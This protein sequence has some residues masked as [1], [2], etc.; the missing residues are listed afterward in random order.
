MS[1]VDAAR[2]S[3]DGRKSK[4]HGFAPGDRAIHENDLTGPGPVGGNRTRKMAGIERSPRTVLLACLTVL[5]LVSSA[6]LAIITLGPEGLGDRSEARES[7]IN[8]PPV[9]SCTISGQ[10]I[11]SIGGAVTFKSGS[12]DPDGTI[13]DFQWDFGDGVVVNGTA[14][15]AQNTTHVYSCG[16]NYLVMHTVRDDG[17]A[18]AS[19]ETSMHWVCVVPYNPDPY[20]PWDNSTTPFAVLSSDKDIIENNTLVNFN[21]TG[22]YGIGGW[23][24][25]NASDP[26]MGEDWNAGVEYITSMVLDFG[27]GTTPAN[28]STINM[29]AAH[30]YAA[31]GH[32]AARLNIT[33]N[34]SGN[35]V[36]TEI[37]ATIHVLSPDLVV[38]EHIKNPDAVV[39]ATIGEPYSLDPAINYDSAGLEVMMSVYET[40]V[41]YDGSSAANLKPVLAQEIPTLTNGLISS[42][43]LN[44][45]F[46]IRTGITFHD[47][48]ALTADDVVYSL[49][50]VLRIHDPSSP[51]WMMSQVLDDYIAYSADRGRTVGYFLDQSAYN[52]TSSALREVLEPLG[53]SHIITEADVQAVAEHVITKVNDTMVNIRLLKPY[54]GF[55][56]ILAYSVGDIVSKDFVEAHGGI[57]NGEVN[58]YMQWHTCGTG[59]YLLVSWEIGSYIYM[60]RNDAYWGPR[61]ALKDAYIIKANDVNTRIS[62]LQGGYADTVYIPVKY[63]SLFIDGTKYEVVK[64]YPT[65]D[66]IFMA[67][68]FNL[69]SATAISQYGGVAITDTFFHDIQVRKAFS[70]MFNFSQ[71]LGNV[72][73]GNGEQPNGVIPNGMWGYDA[74][75]PKYQYSLQLAA[76]DLKN[77]TSPYGDSWFEHGFVLPMFYN[78][79]NLGRQTACEMIHESLMALS[80]MP[81]AGTIDATVNPLDWPQ[82]LAQMYNDYGFMGLYS[83]GWGADFADPDDY[84]VPMLDPDYGTYAFFNGYRNDSITDLLRAAAVELDDTT[85]KQMYSD[86]SMMVY[87]DVPY[88]WLNQPKSFHVQRSWLSGYQF[89]PM[90]WGGIYFPTLSKSNVEPVASFSVLPP[91]GDPT[92]VFTFD[93]WESYDVEDEKSVLEVRW[94]WESDGTWDTGWSTEKIATHQYPVEG[95]YE[96]ALE[97]RDS[98]GLT[99]L[100][101]GTVA[102]EPLIPEFTSIILPIVFMLVMVTAIRSVRTRRQ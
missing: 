6:L 68:N 82:Y 41:W 74:S 46:N 10:C 78:V 19:D 49:H 54:A 75:I 55:L 40:L 23:Q 56:Q 79:G 21:M 69:D 28:V 51:H 9:A 50:R 11:I 13:V 31:P 52:T 18:T 73:S 87:E 57:V 37:V 24:W 95:T 63:E 2:T 53:W 47:G 22:S 16:G 42:D 91:T 101:N 92:T 72:A 89:N 83:V 27:D 35:S 4:T 14:A 20:L 8:I 62:L 94:D 81:G 96:V 93:A 15:E 48:T 88:I 32:Y 44:Y 7:A 34:N 86:I 90:Y 66:I 71:Y 98:N 99:S 33:A 85:R 30:T 97:V 102:V 45:T 26:S 59:P 5:V 36:W 65:F 80:M 77:A 60:T 29:L 64:G 84:T 43:G 12:F 38:T 39:K 67:F 25:V 1:D 70:H 17:G 61:P 76:D 3:F 58:D 100:D